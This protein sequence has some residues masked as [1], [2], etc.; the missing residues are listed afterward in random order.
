MEFAV[1][2]IIIVGISL[3]VSSLGFHLRFLIPGL[4]VTT[5]VFVILAFI[6]R[7][8]WGRSNKYEEI[9]D[10]PTPTEDTGPR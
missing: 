7:N 5:I 3:K 8:L 4:S 9:I 6:R 2:I 1:L 10:T